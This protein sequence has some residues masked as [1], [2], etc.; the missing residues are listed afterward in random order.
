MASIKARWLA[1]LSDGTT[2][3]EGKPPFEEIPGEPSPWQKLSLHLARNG[4]EITGLRIQVERE[5][6]PVRTFNLPSKSP[7]QRWAS[8]KPLL[9]SG[10]N[11]FRRVEQFMEP[12]PD[13]KLQLAQGRRFIEIHARYPDF[14]LVLIVDEDEGNE[15]WTMVLPRPGT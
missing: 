1:S 10:F 13:G 11:Y 14:D 12:T 7:K 8:L 15:C 4:L 6:E 5:G 2:A 9:P 3:I